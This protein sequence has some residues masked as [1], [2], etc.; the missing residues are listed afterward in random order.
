MPTRQNIRNSSLHGRTEPLVHIVDGQPAVRDAL[1]VLVESEGLPA[2]CFATGKDFLD[3]CTPDTH[4]CIL[5]DLRLPEISGLELQKTLSNKGIRTPI[6]FI[7]GEGDV[8]ALVEAFRSGAF[9]FIEKPFENANFVSRLREAIALD[10]KSREHRRRQA[11][12]AAQY[13]RLSKREK[14]VLH[15]T[16]KGYSSKDTAKSLAISHRTVEIYRA[17]VMRKMQ[18]ETL[19]DLVRIALL[20]ETD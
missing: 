19:A 11:E 12:A 6:I 14:Q 20:L 18:A 9:D 7:T 5:L 1:K 8:P 15:C 17:N 3:Y 16:V 2:R 10:L 4:G 13:A